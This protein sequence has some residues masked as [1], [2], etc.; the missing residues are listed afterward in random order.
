LTSQPLFL[1]G[2]NEFKTFSDGYGKP[3]DLDPVLEQFLDSH[4]SFFQTPE[5]LVDELSGL[6]VTITKLDANELISHLRAYL[7]LSPILNLLS[8]QPPSRSHLHHTNLNPHLPSHTLPH[9]H[10][11]KKGRGIA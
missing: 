4:Y 1:C 8:P 7:V 11:S 2:N 10:P 9:S 5:K 3:D 6:G